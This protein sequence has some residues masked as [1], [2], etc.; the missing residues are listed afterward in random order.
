MVEIALSHANLSL[1]L[2]RNAH[3]EKVGELVGS[4]SLLFKHHRWE[5]NSLAGGKNN[6]YNFFFLD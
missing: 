4:C 3:G 2:Q 1:C 5:K 6:I